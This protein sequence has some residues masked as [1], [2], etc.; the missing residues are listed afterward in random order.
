MNDKNVEK[1]N[2]KFEIRTYHCTPVQNFIHFEELHDL[3]SNLP[4]KYFRVE[5]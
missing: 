4:K 1:I 5:Y 2:I 3:G